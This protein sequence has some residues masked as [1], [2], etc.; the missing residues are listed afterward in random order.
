VGQNI[1]PFSVFQSSNVV[2]PS[3]RSLDILPSGWNAPHLTNPGE[4]ICNWKICSL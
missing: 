1:S 2:F 4:P 3:L